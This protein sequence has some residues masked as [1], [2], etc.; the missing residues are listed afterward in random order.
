MIR[1]LRAQLPALLPGYCA[2]ILDGNHLTG[3]EHRIRETRTLNSSP[4]PGQALVVLDPQLRL[5]LNVIPCEDAHTQE[6]SLLGE[7]LP[8]FDAGD[9]AIANRNFCCTRFFFGLRDRNAALL[10]RQH[11]ST[12][13]ASGCWANAAA[14][15]AAS[16][17]WFT[18]R[19]W[20]SQSPRARST[21]QVL[22]LR[23]ITVVLDEPTRDGE[24]VIHLITTVPTDDA[25]AIT[26]AE[27]YLLAGT[28]SGRFKRSNRR[29]GARST[30]SAIPRRP[31]W[32]SALP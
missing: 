15:A 1:K 28:S 21:K 20:R 32:P 3:T 16:R 13:R 6:R 30:R 8:S 17:A 22:C 10:I 14:S 29:C 27:L 24:K 2:K 23:R 9:L 19:H 25:D 31:C 18:S 7:V 4:L 12:W 26:L 11:A 5:V